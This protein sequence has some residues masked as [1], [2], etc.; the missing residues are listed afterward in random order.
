[1]PVRRQLTVAAMLVLC[2]TPLLLFGA[3]V[4]DAQIAPMQNVTPTPGTAP[5]VEEETVNGVKYQVTR[6]TV[7]QVVPVT[8]MQDRQQTTYA[9]QVT[10]ETI[11]HQQAYTVPVTQYEMV[12]TL[13]GRWNPF[14]EPYYTYEMQPVTYYQ[15]QVAS[16]QIPMNKVTWVP[17]TQTVKVPVTEYRTAQQE[18]VT[19]VA[20]TGGESAKT[21]ATAQPAISQ[22]TSGYASAPATGYAAVPAAT[23]LAAT[24]LYTASQPSNGYN[25]PSYTPSPAPSATYP[26]QQN[27]QSAIG[28]QM[29]QTDPPRQG[30]GWS[31]VPNNSGY[32]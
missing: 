17:Q 5:R 11:P 15:E 19:R 22:P 14:V 3:S 9:Q 20:L 29:I 21:Y 2:A 4:A 6:Q 10:T 23:T 1:M 16:V 27:Y 24:P 7:Q 8:I 28:G 26:S 30:T 12:A 18:I 32:R 13:H 31:T 25:Q